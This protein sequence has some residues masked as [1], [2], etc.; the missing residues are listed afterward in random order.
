MLTSNHSG[1]SV[2]V[3]DGVLDKA[4]FI[5]D[6]IAAEYEKYLSEVQGLVFSGLSGS[7]AVLDPIAFTDSKLRD[8]E[9]MEATLS[10]YAFWRDN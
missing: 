6:R 3:S 5:L 10:S 4:H 9:F 7:N 2:S 1:L 8:S